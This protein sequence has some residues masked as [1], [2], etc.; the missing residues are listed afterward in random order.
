MLNPYL[1]SHHM[2]V[3][4]LNDSIP[5]IYGRKSNAPHRSIDI[6]KIVNNFLDTCDEIG[7]STYVS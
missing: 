5:G 6:E 3:A 4:I 1:D 7:V 2:I